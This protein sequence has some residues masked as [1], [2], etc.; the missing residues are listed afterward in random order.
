LTIGFVLFVSYIGI[1]LALS[2][3]G[4]YRP[5]RSGKLRWFGGWAVTD[6]MLWK[7]KGLEWERYLNV[8]CESAT[9][10]NLQGYFFAPLIIVDRT[11]WHP[12]G[13]YF[14]E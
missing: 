7:P 11:Y 9:R 12:T 4:E 5:S 1:Y 14:E 10:G 2:A 8:R 6:R 13:Y 3:A